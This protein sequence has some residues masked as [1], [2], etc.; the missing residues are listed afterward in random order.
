M[1]H[2]ALPD[3]PSYS[4]IP[5]QVHLKNSW[6]ILN[7]KHMCQQHAI[8]KS[9]GFNNAPV[10]DSLIALT[11]IPAISISLTVKNLNFS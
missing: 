6:E 3:A 9:Q 10:Y 4:T 1:R 8:K 7:H 5:N 11:G 2:I